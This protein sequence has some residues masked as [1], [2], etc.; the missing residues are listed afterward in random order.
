MPEETFHAVQADA[1]VAGASVTGASEAGASAINASV[2][3]VSVPDASVDV[4]VVGGGPVGMLLAVELALRGIRPVVLERLS[5]PSGES[6]AGTL[7]ARTAQTLNRRGLL[8]AVGRSSYG[9]VR[10]HFSGMFEL[11]LGTVAG[12]GPTLVGSPQARAEQ[13]FT[14][15]ATELGAE[16]RRGHEVAGLAQ[17]AGRVTLTVDG[18]AGPYELTARYVVGADGARSAVRRLAGIPFTGTGPASRP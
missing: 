16:I 17:D 5:T 9:S 14:D 1:S 15:R 13:V 18:P 3:G 6:K 2:A 10:F 4:V 11:D 12:E 7:H 8:D